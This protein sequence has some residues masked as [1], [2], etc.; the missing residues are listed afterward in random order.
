[1]IQVYRPFLFCMF[2]FVLLIRTPVKASIDPG[3]DSTLQHCQY[4][5]LAHY[6]LKGISAAAYLHGHGVWQG[7]SGVSHDSVPIDSDMVFSIGSITKTFISAEIFKLI[8]A[9]QLSLDD[10]IGSLLPPRNYVRGDI[11]IRHL[12]GHRSGL[13]EYLGID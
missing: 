5:V 6:E 3:L 1:M 2:S 10:T 12:L 9:G 13:A 11:K 8:E 7:L 4:S